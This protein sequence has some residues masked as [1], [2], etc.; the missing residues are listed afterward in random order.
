MGAAFEQLFEHLC[1][2]LFEHLS[3]KRSVSFIFNTFDISTLAMK[4]KSRKIPEVL[5]PNGMKIFCYHKREVPILYEQIQGYTQYGIKLHEGDLVFDVGAN[6]GLFSLWAYQKCQ[7]NLNI[8]AFEPVPIIFD[9]LQ[10]NAQRFDSEK[11][12]VFN[13]GLGQ[14]S[15]NITFAYCPNA[16]SISTAYE[17]GLEE[18]QEQVFQAV[19]RNLKDA[20]ISFRRY[21]WFRL[22]PSFLLSLLI[23]KMLKIAYKSERISC[24]IKTISEIIRDHKVERIDLLKIDV[25]KGE[26]DV[27]LGI[28]VHDWQKVRQIAVEIHDLENRLKKITTLLKEHGFSEIRVDQEPLFK[29]SNIYN[30]YAWRV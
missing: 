23:K 15:K 21:R 9:V 10:A 1:T 20:P 25:E 29:G 28:E 12:K 26:L 17:E 30:L 18:S 7:N 27:F 11:I 22:I 6:I 16:S 13:F 2:K 3:A 5:L 24:Q 14:E 8:Y 4:I 19:V